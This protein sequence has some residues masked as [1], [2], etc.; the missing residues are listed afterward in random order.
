MESLRSQG[1]QEKVPE[2]QRRG[3]DTNVRQKRQYI[4]VNIPV[5]FRFLSPQEIRGETH[6]ELKVTF[7]MEAW[8]KNAYYSVHSKHTKPELEL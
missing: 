1:E 3:N 4:D 7:I 2:A 6:E 8:G 5:L